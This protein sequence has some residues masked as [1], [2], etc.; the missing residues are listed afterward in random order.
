MRAIE[1]DALPRLVERRAPVG[2][3]HVAAG[4]A[5]LARESTPVPTPK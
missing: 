4:F 2:A 5:Q 3:D 1:A